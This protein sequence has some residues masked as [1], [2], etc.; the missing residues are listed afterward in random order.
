M[1][2]SYEYTKEEYERLRAEYQKLREKLSH[3]EHHGYASNEQLRSSF[4][5]KEADY[6][7]TIRQLKRKVDEK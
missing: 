6:E 3:T 4:R 5:D 2:S 7:E 1:K